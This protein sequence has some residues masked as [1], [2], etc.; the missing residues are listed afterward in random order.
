MAG[1]GE[2]WHQLFGR[3]PNIARLVGLD[4]SAEMI[5]GARLQAQRLA[6]HRIELLE[7]DVFQNSIATGSADFILCTF[8]LKTFN[9]EQLQRL[10]TEFQRILKRGGRF[11]LIEVSDPRGWLLRGLYLLY[12]RR[13]MPLI[14]RVFLGY[15]YGY[16]MIGVYVVKFGDCSE[17]GKQLSTCD[18]EVELTRYFFGCAT[19]L[20]G[21]KR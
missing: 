17:F 19:G 1:R 20:S 4:I 9:A 13:I 10:A 3:Q 15:S 12:L 6:T 14:E 8:G 5:K 11:S 21:R 7:Q 18:F 2:T 16:S